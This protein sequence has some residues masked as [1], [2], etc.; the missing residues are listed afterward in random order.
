MNKR[1][2]EKVAQIAQG[3]PFTPVIEISDF[4]SMVVMSGQTAQ[5]ADG[6][7]IK[8][9]I[10]SQTRN[11]ILNCQDKLE[12]AGYS[13]DDVFKVDIYMETFKDWKEM[14][15]V[16]MEMMQDPKPARLALQVKLDPGYL[17]EIQ[18]WAAK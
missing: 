16:Y 2:P 18:M 6:N 12:M 10:K 14:N 13:L 8:G 4:K 7:L 11:T 15:E 1:V 17:I 9:D 5:D 3:K